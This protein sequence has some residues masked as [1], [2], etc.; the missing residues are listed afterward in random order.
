MYIEQI[1][2]AFLLYFFSYVDIK[3]DSFFRVVTLDHY[4]EAGLPSLCSNALPQKR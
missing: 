1:L 2:S 4:F 3:L